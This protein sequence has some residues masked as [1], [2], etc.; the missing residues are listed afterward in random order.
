MNILA[1]VEEILFNISTNLEEF[2]GEVDPLTSKTV[3]SIHLKCAC[4]VTSL[5]L[6][7]APLDVLYKVNFVENI[8]LEAHYQFS[9]TG[10]LIFICRHSGGA[11]VLLSAGKAKSQFPAHET[12]MDDNCINTLPVISQEHGS[13]GC[14]TND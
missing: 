1:T 6:L 7:G 3:F 2:Y 4:L 12:N 9:V 13:H 8:F 11:F 10:F 14:T 5:V